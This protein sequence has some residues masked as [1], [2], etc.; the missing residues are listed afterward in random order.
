MDLLFFYNIKN[1]YSNIVKKIPKGLY[2]FIGIISFIF[3]LPLVGAVINQRFFSELIYSVLLFSIF[4]LIERRQI[5]FKVFIIISVVLIWFMYFLESEYLKYLA[6]SFTVLVFIIATA[7]M[8][9]EIM[10]QKDINAKLI[11]ETINGYLLIG[12]IFSF[13]NLMIL[14][15]NPDAIKFTNGNSL[16]HFGDIIYYS[17][18][19]L[20]SLGFGDISPIA[21]FAKS[22]SIITVI[23][24]QLY[25]SIIMAFIIGKFLNKKYN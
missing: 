2:L 16:D 4:S 10:Q 15:Y 24:G 8:I 17:F 18:T 9:I 19:N 12:I 25:L 20:T 11:F 7:K 14:L 1:M 13:T 6:F 21:S 23:I 22:I 5:W 3:I